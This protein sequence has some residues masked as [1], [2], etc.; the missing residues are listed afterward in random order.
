MQH[1]PE[2]NYETDHGKVLKEALE[3]VARSYPAFAVLQ[4]LA[5]EERPLAPG[6]LV[7][8]YDGSGPARRVYLENAIKAAALLSE[9]E[10]MGMVMINESGPEKY[11][12]GRLGDEVLR[13]IQWTPESL[14][15]QPK[16]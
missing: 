7:R 14:A 9:M 4:N 10:S 2:H 5:I 8:M 11:I 3:Y 13:I 15:A 1:D 6:E 12:T 16:V